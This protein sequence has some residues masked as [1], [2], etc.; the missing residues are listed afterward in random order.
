[1]TGIRHGLSKSP[2][3]ENWEHMIQRCNNPKYSRYYDYGGRG[4]TICERWLSFPNFYNDM[5]ASWRSGLTIER[6][7]NSGNYTPENCRWATR[8]EQSNNTRKNKF[9]EY[10][11]KTLTISQWADFRGIPRH[12]LNTRITRGWATGQAL[13]FK[14]RNKPIR[15]LND[16]DASEIRR[17]YTSGE[18]QRR[19]AKDFNVGQ[20]LISK[21]INNKTWIST[22]N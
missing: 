10:L 15:K 3:Y 8:K 13:G 9:I 7:D 2:I 21:I 6:I 4:I 14:A 1:M 5:S 17:R 16:F 20:T 22:E 11:G 19:I 18:S 12:T